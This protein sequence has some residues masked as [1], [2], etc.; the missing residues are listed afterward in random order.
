MSMKLKCL[1]VLMIFINFMA[2]PSIAKV[3]DWEISSINIS[4]SEE[5]T[6]SAPFSFSEKMVPEMMSLKAFFGK[7]EI[8]S[9][10]KITHHKEQAHLSPI[11]SITSPP[12]EA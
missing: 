8:E 4:V 5:E 1:F 7:F 2:L 6:H 10:Q 11:L 12:P 3:M 9:L